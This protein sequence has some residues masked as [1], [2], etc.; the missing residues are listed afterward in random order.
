MNRR[1]S[2]LK[3]W[4]FSTRPLEWWQVICIFLQSPAMTGMGNRFGF[5]KKEWKRAS[6]LKMF[7]ARNDGRKFAQRKQAL[8]DCLNC[9]YKIGMPSKKGT[10]RSCIDAF[11]SGAIEEIELWI[12]CWP[13]LV[14][15][16]NIFC[17]LFTIKDINVCLQLTQNQGLR[18]LFLTVFWLILSPSVANLLPS[19]G[20]RQRGES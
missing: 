12:D 10:H 18:H 4:S 20:L 1:K 9:C 6:N 11:V 2:I 14:T 7:L 16:S 17:W 13:G 15:N 19:K 8:Q 3:R 5:E